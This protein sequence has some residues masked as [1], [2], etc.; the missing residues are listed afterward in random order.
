MYNKRK[1]II[2][3]KHSFAIALF[4]S[5]FLTIYRSNIFIVFRFLR[6]SAQINVN[7]NAT[8][9]RTFIFKKLGLK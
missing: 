1:W 7:I 5:V 9:L 8:V 2:F 6:L 4:P 3:A